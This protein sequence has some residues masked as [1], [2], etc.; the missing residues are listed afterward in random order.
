MNSTACRAAGRLAALLCPCLLGAAAPAAAADGA[1]AEPG[2]PIAF[3]RAHDREVTALVGSPGD[4][5]ASAV[6]RQVKDLINGV[7]DFWELSRLTLGD[8]WEE[9]S[10]EERQEFVRIY[11]GLVEERNFDR[12]VKYYREGK[13]RYQSEELDGDRATVHATVP[14]EAEELPVTYLLQR[15]DEGDAWRVYD[16]VIDGTS[17]AHVNGRSYIR[18]IRRHS[19][20]K[21]VERLRGQLDKLEGRS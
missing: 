10:S 13:F 4:S 9:R 1:A 21:L 16:L 2:S 17:T 14:L 18:F 3:L 6:R 11:S 5:L 15:S 8:Y 12:F 20:E 19:Y 7:F